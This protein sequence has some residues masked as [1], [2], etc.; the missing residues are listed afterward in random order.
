VAR[1]AIDALELAVAS[2]DTSAIDAVFAAEFLNRTPDDVAPGQT[3][4]GVAEL[5]AAYTG[6]VTD[7]MTDADFTVDDVFVEGDMVAVRYTISGTLDPAAFGLAGEPHP[8]T[9][10]GAH[11]MR[12]ADGQGGAVAAALAAGLVDSPAA[13]RRTA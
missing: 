11:F 13:N 3:E 5:K 1:Q 12:I 7:A 8:V 4:G 9:I 6:A 2:G 10:G